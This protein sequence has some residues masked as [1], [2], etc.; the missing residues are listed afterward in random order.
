MALS[1]RVR[2]PLRGAV[3]L[4][5]TAIFLTVTP[6]VG[7][8]LPNKDFAEKVERLMRWISDH[9]RLKVPD[10]QPAFLFL[11]T[12]TINYVE[13]G[14]R[15]SGQHA[16]VAAFSPTAAG[17]VFLPIEGYTDDVLLHELVHFMQMT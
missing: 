15:Y 14:S 16:V 6:A 7:S 8:P 12:E 2:T 1:I 17:I 3:L 9:S 5:G 4:V 11:P 13:V 10:S